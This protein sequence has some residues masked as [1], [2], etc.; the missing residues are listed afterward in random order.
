MEKF[1]LNNTNRPF[2][3]RFILWFSYSCRVGNDAVVVT[4]IYKNFIKGRSPLIGRPMPKGRRNQ[5][6]AIA[7][8]PRPIK[9]QAERLEAG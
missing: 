6:A 7:R 2:N 5:A 1:L 8:V 3:Y 4:K 9:C